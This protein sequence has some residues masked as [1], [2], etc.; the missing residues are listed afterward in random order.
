MELVQ[1]IKRCLSDPELLVVSDISQSMDNREIAKQVS[2]NSKPIKY[3]SSRIK[4]KIEIFGPSKLFRFALRL[5]NKA[6]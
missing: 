5:Q 2:N 1:L 3:H 6:F 4:S